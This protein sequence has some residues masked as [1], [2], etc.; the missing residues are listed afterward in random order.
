MIKHCVVLVL[1]LVVYI[2][3]GVFRSRPGYYSSAYVG[4]LAEGTLFGN[5]SFRSYEGTAVDLDF[6]NAF[7]WLNGPPVQVWW[8]RK[9][10]L[11]YF[12]KNNTDVIYHL[13]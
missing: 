5:T 6:L 10:L 1:N 3:T 13:N 12:M 8:F 9:A 7:G 2:V 4:L 11:Q